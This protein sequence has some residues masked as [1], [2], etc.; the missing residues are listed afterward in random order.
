MPTSGFIIITQIRIRRLM[1]PSHME[2]DKAMWQAEQDIMIK[3]ETLRKGRNESERFTR[4]MVLNHD[5]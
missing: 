3:S 2:N 5:Q 1:Q 4:E